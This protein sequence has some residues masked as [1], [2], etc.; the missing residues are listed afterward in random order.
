MYAI[1]GIIYHQYT[2][3]VSIYTI[4]GSYGYPNK[5]LIWG[6]YRIPGIP[7]SETRS[8]IGSIAEAELE[9]IRRQL[10]GR[11]WKRTNEGMNKPEIPMFLYGFYCGFYYVLLFL[12]GFHMCFIVICRFSYVFIVICWFSYVFILVTET[13][14]ADISSD[15]HRMDP[16]EYCSGVTVDC[17]GCDFC[18]P[19]C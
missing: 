11:S 18:R 10:E 1:Y 5:I 15:F 14:R 9:P 3:N 8:L 6:V 7:H 12:V 4:H 2:P 17:D 16:S 13:K 19:N